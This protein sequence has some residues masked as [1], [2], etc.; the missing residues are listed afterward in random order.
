MNASVAIGLAQKLNTAT[1]ADSRPATARPA[2]RNTLVL[3]LIIV[4]SFAA[5]ALIVKAVVMINDL[6]L[7]LDLAYKTGGIV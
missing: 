4:S 5:V 6:L 3:G 7:L 1:V 2:Q